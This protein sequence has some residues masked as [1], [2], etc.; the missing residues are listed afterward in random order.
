V[1]DVLVVDDDVLVLRQIQSTLADVAELRVARSGEDALRLCMHRRPD[2]L[3]LDLHL[4]SSNGLDILATLRANARLA[5][6][7][8]IVISN[9]ADTAYVL[10][11]LELGALD[12]LAKPLTDD[13]LRLR[14]VA[15]L[16][17]HLPAAPNP[18]NLRGATVLAIDDDEI[19]LDALGVALAPEG[20]KL[21]RATHATE[22][23]AV[24]ANTSPELVLMDIGM[25][26]VDGFQL[27]QQLLTLPA[28]VDVPIIFVTQNG[29]VRSEVRAF[30]CGAFD[31]VSKP[32]LPAV[33]RARAC[34]AL[35]LRRR[36]LQSLRG[37]EDH[38][39]RVSGEQVAAIV[40]TAGE[41]ILALD[42]DGRIALANEA[43]RSWLGEPMASLAGST[44][45]TW[46]REALPS[47]AFAG[48][49]NEAKGLSVQ[50]P[51]STPAT[52]DLSATWVKKGPEPLLILTFH[53]QTLRLLAQEQARAQL[54]LEAEG[55]AKRLM[56]S[57]LAHEI[58]NPLSG[59]LGLTSL[60]LYPGAEPLTERQTMRLGLV[61]DSAEVLKHLLQDALDLARW[62]SGHF[63]VNLA[64]VAVREVVGVCIGTV[65]PVSR[66][67]SIEWLEASDSA[68]VM[69]LAD[70][71]RLRQCL[72]NLLTN[73][74]KYGQSGGVVR[75]SLQEEAGF[76]RISVVDDGPGMSSSQM[77][78]LFSPFDRL[79]QSAPPG[80]GLGLAVTQMLMKAMSGRIEVCSEVGSGSQFSL[81][82][83]KP[84]DDEGGS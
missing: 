3:I 71:V 4:G 79:D 54:R 76:V 21:L 73:A 49:V 20:F 13:R 67:A 12:W 45:P 1:A 2:L 44:L 11:A 24:L 53:D 69:V 46:L 32:F 31:Y 81:L 42:P 78:R 14:A 77:A 27:A 82:I 51:G 25:P 52:F 8:V 57:Y 23:L 35:R 30:D 48:T 58:G 37:A 64:P 68:D 65:R 56:M 19:V 9:D 34:N 5:D 75:V 10:R 39:R 36:N 72:L 59:I 33:L 55:H 70:P 60:L 84:P 38:W 74:C 6:V 26:G 63:S 22:A 15:A 16:R 62:E 80:H 83:P 40:D 61:R 43:A 66:G 50:R 18:S 7:P 47:G 29:D 28:M 17:H 41:A